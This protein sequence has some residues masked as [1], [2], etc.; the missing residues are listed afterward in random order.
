MGSAKIS[1]YRDRMV[2]MEGGI[3]VGGGDD[4]GGEDCRGVVYCGK[5]KE[6]LEENE[7]KRK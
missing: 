2:T 6:F 7:K 4:E 1:G 3:G 5:K